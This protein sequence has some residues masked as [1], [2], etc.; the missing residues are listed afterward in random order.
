MSASGKAREIVLGDEL[1]DIAVKANGVRVEIHSDGSIAAVALYEQ[2]VV[3]RIGILGN[4]HP[5]TL[6]AK[7]NLADCT[8]FT[9]P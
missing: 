8:A 3:S 2:L 9:R 7:N 5:E 1:G 6:V 4:D